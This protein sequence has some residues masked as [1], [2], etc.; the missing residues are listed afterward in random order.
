MPIDAIREEFIT[1]S[2]HNESKLLSEALGH[3]RMPTAYTCM[4]QREKKKITEQC[5]LILFVQTAL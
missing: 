3:S 4:K 1:T 2:I 5:L